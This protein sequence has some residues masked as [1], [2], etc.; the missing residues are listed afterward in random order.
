MFR[1]QKSPNC[2]NYPDDGPKILVVF[3]WQ[4]F[5][6][7]FNRICS[8]ALFAYAKQYITFYIF[9]LAISYNNINYFPYVTPPRLY[10][11]F[12][13]E[14]FL[15]YDFLNFVVDD[16]IFCILCFRI[17]TSLMLLHHV[18]NVLEEFHLY[19]YDISNFA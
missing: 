9:I 6:A 4:R 2:I 14:I 3:L 17:Y 7:T 10:N 12:G 18:I 8:N 1:S 13:Y 16:L 5:P 19:N 15:K 11:Q